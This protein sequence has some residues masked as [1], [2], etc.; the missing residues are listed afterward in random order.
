MNGKAIS[1][2]FGPGKA[3]FEPHGV[4]IYS[5]GRD[6]SKTMLDLIYRAIP[7]MKLPLPMGICPPAAP[8]PQVDVGVKRSHD[9][10]HETL[11]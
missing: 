8:A 3:T 6:T 10:D 11:D 2:Y 5:S 7:L 4:R 9:T 1:E